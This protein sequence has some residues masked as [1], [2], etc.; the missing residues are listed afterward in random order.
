MAGGT[1]GGI[2]SNPSPYASIYYLNKLP[3]NAIHSLPE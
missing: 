2:E 3:F 1:S